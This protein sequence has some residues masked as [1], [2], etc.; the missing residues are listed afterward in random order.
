MTSSRQ[1]IFTR[2][3]DT[4]S[5]SVTGAVCELNCAHCG[6]KYLKGMRPPGEALAVLAHSNTKSVLISGGSDN[7][8][9]VPVDDWP[10]KF[11]AGKRSLKINC[12]TGVISQLEASELSRNVD[13][14]SFDYVSDERIIK[15]VYGSLTPAADYVKS[16]INASRVTVT[17][18]H[19]TL[20]LLGPE[21]EPSLG[22]RSILEI[23][24]LADKGMIPVPRSVVFIVLKPTLG[25]RMEDVP[26]PSPKSVAE[27]IQEAKLQF[28][29]TSIALGCMRPAGHY[30]QQLDLLAIDAGIDVLV[31][32]SAAAAKYAEEK[33]LRIINDTECCV[34]SSMRKEY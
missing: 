4:M 13:V 23:R 28:P 3:K 8:G 18:P 27:V 15:G 12:H 30:R 1:I 25:T 2:P 20:G 14:I 29:Q 11:K 22:I 34:F 21:E 10:E 7:F 26:A 24:E 19:I 17:V 6:A 32:P 31:M 5:V 33:G 9:H 16:F